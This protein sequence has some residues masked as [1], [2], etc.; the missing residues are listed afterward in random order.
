VEPN[1]ATEAAKTGRNARIGQVFQRQSDERPLDDG[2]WRD[3]FVK[4]RS[5][6]FCSSVGAEFNVRPLSG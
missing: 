6:N 5:G 4:G 3:P 2:E 1:A